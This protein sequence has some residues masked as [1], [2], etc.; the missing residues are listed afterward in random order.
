MKTAFA[1]PISPRKPKTPRKKSKSKEK[2]KVLN[3]VLILDPPLSIARTVLWTWWLEETTI[4]RRQRSHRL[5]FSNKIK[6]LSLQ[7][8]PIT[9]NSFAKVRVFACVDR[10]YFSL[11]YNL[12]CSL[13]AFSTDRN[14]IST[15]AK[16]KLN[17]YSWTCAKLLKAF[18]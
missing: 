12:T 3:I 2:L 9:R 18:R 10:F 4:R 7:K 5:I 16:Q 1:I 14:F 15:T 17:W 6:H 13:L 11:F 8:R